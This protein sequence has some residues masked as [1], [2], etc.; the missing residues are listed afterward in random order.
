MPDYSIII[1]TYN[2]EKKITRAIQSI[3]DQTFTSWELL[4]V[5]DGST[6]STAQNIKP[7]LEDKRIRYIAQENSGVSAARHTGV[8]NSVGEFICFLDGDDAVVKNWL[9][10]FNDL[11]DVD[12]GYISCGFQLNEKKTYPKF[13]YEISEFKYSSLAGTFALRKTVYEEI[14]GYDQNLRESENYEMTA[15]AVEYCYKNGLKLV[16]IDNCNFIYHLS[17]TPKQ[18]RERDMLIAEAALYL[19]QK[20]SNGGILY[21]RKD[22]YLKTAAVNFI[23]AG[24]LGRGKSILLKIFK[25]KP[26][27][28]SCID[29]FIVYIPI[30]RSKIWM[31]KN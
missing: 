18:T 25:N 20:Y 3:L 2:N 15:R 5:N 6:D 22:K 13:N 7:F 28:K 26:T 17:K 1:P 4:I 27:L 30:L 16:Y 11:K 12:T 10:D 19:H 8:E 14:G 21:F 29:L 23:R 31:R 9:A 24:K